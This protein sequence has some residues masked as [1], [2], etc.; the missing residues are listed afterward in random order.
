MA[1]SGFDTCSGWAWTK[2]CDGDVAAI[3]KALRPLQNPR[4]CSD[5]RRPTHRAVVTPHPEGDDYGTYTLC[6]M[7]AMLNLDTREIESAGWF[8]RMDYEDR[9]STYT[10]LAR[11]TDEIRAR[12]DLP[13]QRPQPGPSFNRQC[14][15]YYG[16]QNIAVQQAF[17]GTGGV[18][19]SANQLTAGR[20]SLDLGVTKNQLSSIASPFVYWLTT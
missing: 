15:E 18:S 2:K 19:G 20:I 8:R 1:S 4:E 10:E 7:C 14:Q 16:S 17:T 11:E 5:C 12:D 3:R 9:R 6:A 13:T